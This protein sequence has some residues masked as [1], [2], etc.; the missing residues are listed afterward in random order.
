MDA[1]DRGYWIGDTVKISHYLD[2]DQ[3]GARRVRNWTII[4]AEEIVP[5][6]IVQYH[7]EDTTLY[8]RIHFIMANGSADYPGVDAAPFKNAYIGNA[9]GLLSDGTTCGRIS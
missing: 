7:V 2:R 4:S 6:E 3:Y 5:G 1:K 8:G 9:A